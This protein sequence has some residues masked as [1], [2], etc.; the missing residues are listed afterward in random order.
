[1]LLHRY[2][3]WPTD[4]QGGNAKLS[5][6]LGWQFF[7]AN[8]I[9]VYDKKVALANDLNILPYLGRQCSISVGYH[10]MDVQVSITK[11]I[12]ATLLAFVIL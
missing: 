6:K 1:M 7:A 8:I 11:N 4:D 12:S 3:L 5:M 2:I 10:M 9:V